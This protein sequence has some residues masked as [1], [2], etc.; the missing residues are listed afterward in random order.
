M[1]RNML[2]IAALL[3][4]NLVQAQ[5]KLVKLW[6]T[7]TLL[8]VPESVLYDVRNQ[9]LYASNIDGTNPWAKD[10]KGSIAKVALDG[11]I[12]AAEWITGL[13]APKGMGRYKNELYVADMDEVIVID[14]KQNKI[15][16]RIPVSGAQG[17][18]DITIDKKGL[19]YVSD[20]KAKKVYQ[21]KKGVATVFLE[22]L[23]GPNGVLI[24]KKKLYLL[25]NGGMYQVAQDKTLTRIADGMEGGTDG[26]EHVQ[27][28]EFIVSCWAGAI[29]YIN[30]DG[31]K[32]NLLD[33]R[34]QKISSADIGY[35]AK[36]RIVYVPTFWHN[37][38]VAYRLQ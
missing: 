12:I 19:L 18:N 16:Q 15:K 35:D 25:D 4:F 1:K 7:D 33:T 27:A 22:N 29:W 26:I 20:S 28:K 11:K 5:P 10:G 37:T 24:H 38:I 23:K 31:T 17:L 13:H 3:I 6:E 8:K 34:A 21:V 32:T 14:I 2:L 36:N 9:V 30:G